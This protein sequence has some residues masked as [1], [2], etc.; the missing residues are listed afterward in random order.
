[1]ME[2]IMCLAC[3]EILP[4]LPSGKLSFKPL[5]DHL[6]LKDKV[7]IEKENDIEKYFEKI[8]CKKCKTQDLDR[9]KRRKDILTPS[10]CDICYQRQKVAVSQDVHNS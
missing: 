5:F 10:I 3:K 1:M 8:E 7:M 4:L 9:F 6:W 2:R